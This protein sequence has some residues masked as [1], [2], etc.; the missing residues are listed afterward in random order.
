LRVLR[1]FSAKNKTKG[2][3]T[4]LQKTIRKTLRK[5]ALKSIFKPVTHCKLLP[6]GLRRRAHRLLEKKTQKESSCS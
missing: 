1:R 4:L 5:K 3:Q 6:K 2:K